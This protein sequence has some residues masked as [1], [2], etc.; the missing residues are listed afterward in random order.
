MPSRL[1]EPVDPL[2]G[3]APHQVVVEREKEARRARV[4]LAAGAAAEL[5]VDPAR[6][7]ALGADDVQAADRDDLVVVVLG[8]GLG[9]GEAA[10]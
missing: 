2:A 3:E 9:L 8:D 4:A 7:V 5:V 10:S 6:L 1:H